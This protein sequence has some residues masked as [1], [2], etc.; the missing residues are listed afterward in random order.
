MLPHAYHVWL[1][2]DVLMSAMASQITSVSI[3]CSSVYLGADQRKL[4]SF[5]SLAFV[6]GI[7]RSPV[8]SPYKGQ[9]RRKCFHLMT[10]SWL[11]YII[12]HQWSEWSINVHVYSTSKRIPH[13]ATIR[14]ILWNM[15]GIVVSYFVVVMLSC[16]T[17]P[18]HLFTHILQGCFKGESPCGMWVTLPIT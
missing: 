7:H 10:S 11:R 2:S 17:N 9:Q 12:N 18:C 1:Y 13:N 5:A 6:R 3:V 15:H 16:V 4:Q 14:Y 8:D